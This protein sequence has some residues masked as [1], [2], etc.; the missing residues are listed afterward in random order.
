[1]ARIAELRTPAQ[2]DMIALSKLPPSDEPIFVTGPVEFAE[3]SYYAP[4]E[5]RSRLIYPDC[6]ELDLKYLGTNASTFS[7]EGLAQISPLKV[8]RCDAVLSNR[9]P[10]KLVVNGNHYLV[11]VL[12]SQGR[13]VAPE[14]VGNKIIFDVAPHT[15]RRRAQ[16]FVVRS[17]LRAASRSGR[18]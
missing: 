11:P 6:P 4:A 16:I 17:W 15:D 7:V 10:F 1:M 18:W 5:L 14:D 3:L 9:K 13:T 8:K 2:A 12:S